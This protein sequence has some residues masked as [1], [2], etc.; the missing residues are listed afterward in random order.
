MRSCTDALES[1]SSP[2]RQR[3][4]GRVFIRDVNLANHCDP[5]S[6]RIDACK[7]SVDL[8]TR[9]IRPAKDVVQTRRSETVR[10]HVLAVVAFKNKLAR[11]AHPFARHDS[12]VGWIFRIRARCCRLVQ[13]RSYALQWTPARRADTVEPATEPRGQRVIG[14]IRTVDVK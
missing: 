5:T 2:S 8:I 4:V 14:R 3:V 7:R 13:V 6:R 9:R 12:G 10:F 1:A 11:G